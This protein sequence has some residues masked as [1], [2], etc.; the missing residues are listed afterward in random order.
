MI[1]NRVLTFSLLV[2]VLLTMPFLDYTL[3]RIPVMRIYSTNSPLTG[4][5]TYRMKALPHLR[6]SSAVDPVS[7]IVLIPSTTIIWS[8]D[9]SPEI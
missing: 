9:C 7:V 1:N 4:R 8:S 6:E 2:A 3:N 5:I